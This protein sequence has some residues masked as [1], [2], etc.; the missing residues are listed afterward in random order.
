M[1]KRL[2]VVLLILILAISSIMVYFKKSEANSINNTDIVEVEND[3]TEMYLEDKSTEYEFDEED[4]MRMDRQGGIDVA[5]I[6]NNIFEEDKEYLVFEVM[7]NNHRVDLQDIR[8][9]DL[10]SLTTSEG[11]RI[12]EGL[13]WELAGGGGHHISGYLKVPKV[14]NG[15]D[16]INENTEYI[17]IEI[18]GLGNAEKMTFQWDKEVLDIYKEVRDIP[19]S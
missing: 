16:I 15:E 7:V 14:Y 11:I 19:T 13:Q 4:M 10:S 3:N 18:E 6:F 5:I 9:A 1:I 8:Y 17:Q 2:V 12:D